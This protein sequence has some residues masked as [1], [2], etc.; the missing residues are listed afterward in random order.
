MV[1]TSNLGS[2]NGHWYDERYLSY[3]WVHP[4]IMF[5][6]LYMFV[7]AYNP[8]NALYLYT[9]YPRKIEVM[10]QFANLANY[11]EPVCVNGRLNVGWY[12]MHGY[13]DSMDAMG[14]WGTVRPGSRKAA[15]RKDQRR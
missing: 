1:G 5:V 2:W 8:W 11:G 15:R 12:G 4:A 13:M 14:F 10:N 9:I 6:G 7:T 3:E